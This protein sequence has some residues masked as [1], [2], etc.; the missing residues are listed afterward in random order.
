MAKETERG[1][2]HFPLMDMGGR[3]G[4]VPIPVSAASKKKIRDLTPNHF[5]TPHENQFAP[6][7]TRAT[8]HLAIAA[9]Q[10]PCAGLTL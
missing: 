7:I 1:V 5:V 9:S 2:D 10:Q 4:C 8:L 6:P 3:H